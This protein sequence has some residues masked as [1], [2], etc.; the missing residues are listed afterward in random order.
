MN[1]DPSLKTLVR[2]LVDDTSR[3]FRQ[4]L[5]LAQ[6]EVTDNIEKAQSKIVLMLVGLLLAF[7]A[8]LI[9]LQGIVMALATAMEPWAAS[10]LV[11][12]ITGVAALILVKSGQNALK[13]QPIAPQRTMRQVKQDKELVMEKVS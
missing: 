11:A 8:V 9:L 1:H 6:R 12:A 2:Q 5:R 4:E 3:L 10:V 7:C 13:T